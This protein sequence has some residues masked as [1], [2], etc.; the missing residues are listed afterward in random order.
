MALG[1]LVYP[2]RAAASA[3]PGLFRPGLAGKRRASWRQET[4][5][6]D[7]STGRFSE[8]PKI[9]RRSFDSFARRGGRTRSG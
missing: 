3:H 5:I 2:Q 4:R 7:S 8:I 6:S 9:N 1:G